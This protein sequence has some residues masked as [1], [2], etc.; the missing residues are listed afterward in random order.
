ML[1]G[2]GNPWACTWV[3][4]SFSKRTNRQIG[5]N[6]RKIRRKDN[7]VT[8]FVVFHN[9]MCLLS[10]IITYKY[11]EVIHNNAIRVNLYWK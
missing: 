9:G 3:P 11:L 2:R 6:N 7:T 8:I 1:V 10:G 5:V 4:F